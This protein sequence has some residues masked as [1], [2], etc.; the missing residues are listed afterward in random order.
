MIQLCM[1]HNI[2]FKKQ[3]QTKNFFQLV[4]IHIFSNINEILINSAISKC[5]M[6]NAHHRNYAFLS[7]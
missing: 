5:T 1:S 4:S 3:K 7:G 6:Q 2:E